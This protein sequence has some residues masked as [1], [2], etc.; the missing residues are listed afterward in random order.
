M[1][2]GTKPA[3][4]DSDSNLAISPIP[5]SSFWDIL[6]W[7]LR[8]RRRFQ[9]VGTSMLPLLEPGDEILVDCNSYQSSIPSIG[10]VVVVKSPESPNLNLV[11]RVVS[12]NPDGTCFLQG[13]N[14]F[15]STDS[16]DFG[17]VESHLIVGRVTSRFF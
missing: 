3:N 13:D 1:S 5:N 2:P 7:L 15:H 16:W 12:I 8:Q 11:K 6:L 9:V 4:F 17:W 10:D 14:R